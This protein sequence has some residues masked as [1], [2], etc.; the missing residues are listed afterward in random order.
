M[1]ETTLPINLG[2]WLLAISPILL[3]LLLLAVLRWKAPQAGPVG[4]FL[5]VAVALL[6]FRAPWEAVAVGAPWSLR[7]CWPR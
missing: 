4:M 5:A 7:R 3:L 2:T 6:F 1:S